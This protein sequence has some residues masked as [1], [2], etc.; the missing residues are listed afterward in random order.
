M[1]KYCDFRYKKTPARK[2]RVSGLRENI[3]ISMNYASGVA[4][5]AGAAGA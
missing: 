1:I 4:G 2:E 3:I 5:V